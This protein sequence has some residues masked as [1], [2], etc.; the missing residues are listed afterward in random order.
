MNKT[1]PAF[2][3]E[4]LAVYIDGQADT[5]LE[6]RIAAAMR[7]DPVF[8]AHVDTLKA[9]IAAMQEAFALSTLR[10]P[11][12]PA[13]LT[14]APTPQRSSFVLPLAIAASFALGVV[15][16]NFTRPAPGWI[17]RVA[18]YQALYVEDTLMGKVQ[19]VAVTQLVLEQTQAK[20]GV[21]LDSVPQLDGMVFKRVQILAIDDRTLIQFAYL[22]DDGTTFALCLVRVAEQDRAIKNEQ[23][24]AL[25][26]ASWVNNG[27]GFVLIGGSD[28]D[29]VSDLAQGLSESI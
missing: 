1:T 27:I 3:D 6:N 21:D 5:G 12:M 15:T 20:L 18:S 4:E 10:A 19:D 7:D 8:A 25:A 17:D 24:H 14:P 29:R 2:S 23:S 22:A 28:N 26:T 9:P 16:T 13:Y 11:E